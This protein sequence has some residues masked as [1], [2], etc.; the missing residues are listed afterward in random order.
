MERKE[1]NSIPELISQGAEAKI[2]LDKK[3]NLI[4][5]NRLSKSY[6][7]Q[8]LDKKIIKGRTKSEIK[9]LIKANQIINAPLPGK[10]TEENKI[11]MPYVKGKKLSDNLN[12]F[13]LEKQK[14]ILEKIG[15]SIAILHKS[16]IIH[17]DLTT[18]NMILTKSNEVFFIDFGLGYISKIKRKLKIN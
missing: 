16:D 15:K 5:K 12:N 4:I 14:E 6:R 13:S 11:I 17:G 7:L 1:I 9:L 18:S 3:K 2:F 10:N 8:E